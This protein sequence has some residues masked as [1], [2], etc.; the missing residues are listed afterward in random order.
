MVLTNEWTPIRG[1]RLGKA[2]R[3]RIQDNGE[4]RHRTEGR[5]F[6]DLVGFMNLLSIDGSLYAMV[7]FDEL[8][9]YKV[10]KFLKKMDVSRVCQSYMAVYTTPRGIKVRIVRTDNDGGFQTQFEN[11]LKE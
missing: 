6:I 4:L 9:R 2:H 8:S 3:Y 11:M 1:V 5:L 10:V 7:I